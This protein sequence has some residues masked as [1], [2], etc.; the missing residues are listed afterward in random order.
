MTVI[1]RLILNRRILQILLFFLFAS[2]HPKVHETE[3]IDLSQASKNE[4][5]LLSVLADSVKY[6]KLQTTKESSFTKINKIEI[7]NGHIILYD[8]NLMK[9]LVF[10]DLGNFVSVIRKVG[11]SLGEYTELTDFCIDKENNIIIL[12]NSQSHLLFY[13]FYGQYIKTL[14]IKG[15]CS[16]IETI[17]NKYYL[18]HPGLMSRTN[19][20][21]SMSVLS[22]NNDQISRFFKREKDFV[23]KVDASHNYC[24][25]K[26]GQNIFYWEDVFENAWTI[27]DAGP[28]L[29][30]TYY[31]DINPLPLSAFFNKGQYAQLS[32]D[33]SFIIRIYKFENFDFIVGVEKGIF[34][35]YV[36]NNG[37]SELTSFTTAFKNNLDQGLGFLIQ[38]RI[39]DHLAVMIWDILTLRKLVDH[40]KIKNTHLVELINDSYVFDNPILQVVYF[41]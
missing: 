17:G 25:Y 16:N 35:Y 14:N 34:N 26:N 37:T 29:D 4:G 9:I 8:R 31:Y 28:K 38:N 41:K 23:N 7:I 24:F 18:L 30:R 6:I 33:K 1:L 39:N 11:K 12:D 15:N 19:S 20:Y 32:S 36:Y 5:V 10:D 2:C 3:R 13:T 27:E 21:N 22:D 40:N